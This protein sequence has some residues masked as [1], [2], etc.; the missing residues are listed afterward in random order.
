M[1]KFLKPRWLTNSNAWQTTAAAFRRF[2]RAS[3]ALGLLLCWTALNLMLNVRFPAPQPA[4][5]YF[6]PSIDST[7]VL[8]VFALIGM[9]AHYGGRKVGWLK[10]L[11]VPT[12]LNI[13]L[14]AMLLLVRVFRV[15][16]G[17]AQTFQ[18]RPAS[19]F[20]DGPMVGELVRLLY[21]TMPLY[22]FVLV[23]AATLV[24]VPA[25]VALCYACCKALSRLLREPPQAA[26]F[27]V[28]SLLFIGL[29]ALRPAAPE[30]VATPAA[31][32][33][34][35]V[36]AAADAE[37]E[38]Y[39]G[40]FA[41]SVI[42]RWLADYEAYTQSVEL[43]KRRKQ[44]LLDAGEKFK[45]SSGDLRKLRGT[46]V[47]LFVVE[48]YGATLLTTPYYEEGVNKLYQS[49]SSSFDTGGYH[50][51]STL[52]DSPTYGGNSWLAHT[53]LLTGIRTPNQADFLYVTRAEPKGLVHFF[54]E[55]GYYTISAEP[56]TT[57][58]GDGPDLFKFD[59][60]IINKTFGYAGP[61]YSWAPMPDQLVIDYVH[62]E[63]ITKRQE[64]LFIKYA[65]V[66]S[67]GPWNMQPPVLD[68]WSAIGDGAIYNNVEN[69]EYPTSWTNL[70][71]AQGPY[72]H[73]IEYT[74]EVIRR[75]LDEF[76]KDDSLI[77]ILG[78]HQPTGQLTKQSKD[79]R[80]PVHIV[81]RNQGFVD[82]F[83]KRGYVPGIRPDIERPARAMDTFAM[84]F[85]Q[86]FSSPKPKP[87][88]AQSNALPP[89]A[90]PATT[91]SNALPPQT[92]PAANQPKPATSH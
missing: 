18:S 37:Q 91:Q 5:A 55:A 90:V 52:L 75:Y 31:G 76:V 40:A 74:L 10:R 15:G 30:P 86:D 45:R 77:I 47:L 19:L 49:L 83:I 22:Q 80:V 51:A 16:D 12:L 73:S 92:V 14:G 65:L 43:A 54:R 13:G 62:R 72:L 79:M 81:S 58:P 50:Y 32:K 23:A 35:A 36:T 3:Q 64:P 88:A 34:K 2:P 46:N 41:A 48:S 6:L 68:D 9:I 20:I 38:Q 67:H 59:S 8:A 27:A 7:V 25:L 66:S 82:K 56:G 24:V 33:T 71:E 61:R 4:G 39:Q 29:S 70:G 17:I 84:N 78:D 1:L 11:R 69:L 53:T 42:P 60:R 44:R 26:I 57:R 85:L 63:A 87:E 21:T 89:Q 28:I